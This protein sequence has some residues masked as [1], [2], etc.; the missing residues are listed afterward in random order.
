M[1]QRVLANALQK[2]RQWAIFITFIA[3]PFG[4]DNRPGSE[5][6][7]RTK[8]S[9]CQRMRRKRKGQTMHNG[10]HTKGAASARAPEM[11]L[12]LPLAEMDTSWGR[13][14]GQLARLLRPRGF[15][16]EWE[17]KCRQINSL[18]S[19]GLIVRDFT[20]LSLS[21]A[22]IRPVS[23]FLCLFLSRSLSLPLCC[24]TCTWT[25]DLVHAGHFRIV[26]N[27]HVA[28]IAHLFLPI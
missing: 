25:I 14:R 24:W 10:W 22:L 26:F 11:C 7:R 18:K 20:Q 16:L 6:E 21:V 28:T 23:L 17:I 5:C 19:R 9:G 2:Q 27:C 13:L 8:A 3:M 1:A 15:D 12:S 4:I